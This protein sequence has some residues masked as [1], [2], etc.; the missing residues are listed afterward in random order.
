MNAV[1]NSFYA[2]VNAYHLSFG[3]RDE[4]LKT[5][6]TGGL[7]YF[8]YGK[9]AETDAAGKI[10]GNLKPTDWMMQ[11]AVTRSYLQKWNYG[12]SLKFISSNSAFTVPMAWLWMPAF[13]LRILP[14][15]FQLRLL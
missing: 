13:F 12:I 1:F 3:Y 10:L 6:F 8:D 5:N 2:G 4:K 7:T 11:V 15:C 9:V 14:I